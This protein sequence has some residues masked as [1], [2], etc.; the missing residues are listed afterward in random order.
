VTDYRIWPATNGPNAD[1]ADNAINLGIQFSVS[2]Q[3]W[4]IALRYYRGTTNVNPDDLRLW[5]VDSAVSGTSLANVVPPA[6]GAS[7]GWQEVA[8]AT[9]VELTPGQVYKTVGHMPTHY[10]ATPNYW[11]SGAGSAGITNGI[12]TAQSNAA[13]TGGQGTF[14]YNASPVFPTSTFNGGNY[15]IDVVVTDVDPAG[16]IVVD[17]GQALELSSAQLVTP[18]HTGLLDQALEIATG[19]VVVTGTN[20]ETALRVRASGTEPTRVTQG[21]EPRNRV[22]GNEVGD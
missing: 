4:V 22:S 16:P 13:S 15:W 18:A 21:T 12:L 20:V 10:V 5:Q 9:P 2:A 7:I 11:T 17:V 3:A 14:T 19:G 1:N 6:A 8:L